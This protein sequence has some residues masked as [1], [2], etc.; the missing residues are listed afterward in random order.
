MPL[1]VTV[2]FVPATIDLSSSDEPTMVPKPAPMPVLFTDAI[3]PLLPPDPLP[4]A[5]TNAPSLALY[6]S[7]CSS[8]K[9]STNLKVGL[10]G[11]A[12]ILIC[13]AP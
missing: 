3:P 6:T 10:N 1:S 13:L 8:C 11:V 4:A 12:F 5:L 7:T 9:L 2:T